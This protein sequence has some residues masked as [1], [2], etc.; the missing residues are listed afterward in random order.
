MQYQILD[1][2]VCFFSHFYYI[3]SL[4]E[5]NRINLIVGIT[6]LTFVCEYLNCFEFAFRMMK[7]FFR[8]ERSNC[9]RSRNYVISAWV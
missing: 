7:L 8:F 2:I 6:Y 5:Q 9:V 3:N 4:L 1:I